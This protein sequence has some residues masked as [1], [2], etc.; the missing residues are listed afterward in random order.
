TLDPLSPASEGAYRVIDS[1]VA[2]LPVINKEGRLLGIVTVDA[3]IA[4]VAP[5][6]WRTQ[7]PRIF[8]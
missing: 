4:Q 1:H 3:A 6:N 7:A 5:P 8:S 2:A